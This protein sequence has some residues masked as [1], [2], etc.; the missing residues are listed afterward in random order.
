[1][2][3]SGKETFDNII[4]RYLWAELWAIVLRAANMTEIRPQ[5]P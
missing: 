4:A 2:S 5:T 3:G 1:M